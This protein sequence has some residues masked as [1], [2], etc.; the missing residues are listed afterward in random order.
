MQT[1]YKNRPYID[2]NHEP[3]GCLDIHSG[4]Q[5]TASLQ[6]SLHDM[7]PSNSKKI[8]LITIYILQN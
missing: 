1:Y 3:A 2:A 5:R 6:T 8:Y 4:L 7:V